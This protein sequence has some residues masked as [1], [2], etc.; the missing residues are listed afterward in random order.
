[1]GLDIYAGSFV[2]YYARNWKTVAQQFCE[3]NG[4]QYSQISA[5]EKD[6]EEEKVKVFIGY[7]VC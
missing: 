1:M 6:L 4:L 5:Q 3:E 2:R 7:S